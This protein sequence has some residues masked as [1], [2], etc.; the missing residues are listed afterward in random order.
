MLL[1]LLTL[2]IL[3]LLILLLLRL[4]PKPKQIG[5]YHNNELLAIAT[6]GH[7]P[8]Y[9]KATFTETLNT[10]E[11]G[12]MCSLDI[13]DSGKQSTFLGFFTPDNSGSLRFTGHRSGNTLL[14]LEHISISQ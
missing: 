10:I 9:R 3:S 6:A 7:W 1:I 11:P 2:P 13:F 8:N 5:I 12:E 4:W 14:P